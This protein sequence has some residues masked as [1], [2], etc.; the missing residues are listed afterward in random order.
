MF[1]QKN[2]RSRAPP[3]RASVAVFMRG[4]DT[5]SAANT[6]P[7]PLQSVCHCRNTLD[8]FV[9]WLIA[10]P[11]RFRLD[12]NCCAIGP[13]AFRIGRAELSCI[14]ASA[15]FRSRQQRTRPTRRRAPCRAASPRAQDLD[16]CR[17]FGLVILMPIRAKA[18]QLPQAFATRARVCPRPRE[19]TFPPE[20]QRK[21]NPEP[22]RPRIAV[23]S[24]RQKL[25]RSARRFCATGF[26]TRERNF[27][28]SAP[29]LHV[30][31]SVRAVLH[32][33]CVL[34]SVQAAA[35][36]SA[37]PMP[38]QPFDRRNRRSTA[39]RQHHQDVQVRVPAIRA[40]RHFQRT[41]RTNKVQA[42]ICLSPREARI[43]SVSPASISGSS[44]GHDAALSA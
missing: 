24:I 36:E 15:R 5:I 28:R 29:F 30:I 9:N 25:K 17:D 21:L 19:L 14:E 44:T 12:H 37:E 41:H 38:A 32:V 18:A 40:M 7:R 8:S 22:R 23:P 27:F 13:P 43:C 20:A 4:Q 2:A 34:I 31:A 16:F 42:R 33:K 39:E 3:E 10:F 35:I 1:G 6:P 11:F 26:S